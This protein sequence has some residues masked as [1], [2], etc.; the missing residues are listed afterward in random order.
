MRVRLGIFIFA[1]WVL[2]S[3]F[4]QNPPALP[5]PIQLVVPEGQAAPPPVI[6]LQDALDRAKIN[7]LQFLSAV[8]DAQIAR[9]DVLQAKNSLRPTVSSAWGYFG[10]QG[11]G[12]TP[13]GRYVTT[14]GV[15][16]YRA[17]AVAHEDL[18]PN[19]V[20]RTGYRR[21]QAT[22]ALANAR[23]EI[24]QRGLTVTVTRNYYALVTS[25]RKYATAQQSAQTA[26]RFL[27][28]AQQQENVGQVAHADVVKAQI[29][30][31]Q[32]NQIFE[33]ALL[34]M[35][36]ARLNLAVLL[37]PTLNENFT[38]VDDLASAQMLPPFPDIRVMA[39]RQNPDLRVAEE[40]V[41]QAGLDVSSARYARLP[42]LTIDANY[43]LEANALKLHAVQAAQPQF[44][45]LPTL[46]YYIVGSLNVPIWDW[47]TQRSKVR[48]AQFRE[49]QARVQLT[50][51]QRQLLSNLYAFYNE[52]MV[53]RSAVDRL[54]RAA[55]LATESLRLITLRYQA[56]ESTALEVV[57]AQNTL[58]QSR[59]AFDDAQAR[60]RNALANLQTVTGNF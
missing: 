55:D 38:V 57:D 37:F 40:T 53:A 36:N 21:A 9:E 60:Y 12:L 10:T 19:N 8:T 11:D 31:E 44:G 52:A 51:A 49:Q 58:V 43:G 18:S 1:F 3:A 35:Q 50:Q 2:P 27:D 20:F 25:Q 14:D 5:P 16:V 41:R 42:S 48:Q 22:E 56:G 45:P 30:Y 32:Q 7:D 24:A 28:I 17:W 23:I 47:G 59:N 46:G 13:N 6:T 33:E 29:Q 34:A 4:A 15:H 39:E 26:A 54:R